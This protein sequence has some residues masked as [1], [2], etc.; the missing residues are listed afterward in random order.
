MIG[1]AVPAH[2]STIQLLSCTLQVV[3]ACV[4]S[5]F[6]HISASAPGRWQGHP[7]RSGAA[8][9]ATVGWSQQRVAAEVQG[10]LREVLGRT[11][12][13]DEPLM[14]GKQGAGRQ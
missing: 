11:L 7:Q 3:P 1:W 8:A 6:Q 14:S 9:A 2:F 5:E 4:S 12:L 10:A 13:P